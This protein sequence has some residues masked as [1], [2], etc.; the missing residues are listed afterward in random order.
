MLCSYI[1]DLF[2]SFRILS[3]LELGWVLMMAA[4]PWLRTWLEE[5][6]EPGIGPGE[7]SAKSFVGP[8]SFPVLSL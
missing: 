1:M 7:V 8:I 5:E 2:R 4:C 3:T 6:S